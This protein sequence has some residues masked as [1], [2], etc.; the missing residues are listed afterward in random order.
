MNLS[1]LTGIATICLAAGAFALT[2]A[3]PAAASH[4]GGGGAGEV[5]A[6][7]H[8]SASS[9]WKLKAKPD[10]GRIEL[11]LEIDT[12]RN[13][14]AWAVG[15]TDNTVRIFSGT[16]TTQAPSGSFE[17]ELRA[18]NRAGADSFVGSA[19]NTRTGQTCT[20]RVRL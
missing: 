11:E 20:A 4:G 15:I 8:C 9:V 18:A 19:R 7:G 12:P 3:L 10:N 16:R 14:Q 1:R 5:R 17:V 6:S 13:G 2:S